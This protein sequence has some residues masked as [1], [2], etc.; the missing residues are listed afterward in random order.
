MKVVYISRRYLSVPIK[1]KILLMGIFFLLGGLI[2]CGQT[3][4]YVNSNATG[5]NN[6]SSWAD[7]FTDLQPALNAAGASFDFDKRIWVAAGTYRPTQKAGNGIEERDQSFT[8]V[9]NAKVYGGFT[10][11]EPA[12]FN[13][14]LRNIRANETILSGDIG[15]TGDVADNSYH[16]IISAGPLGTARLDGFTIK[17]GNANGTTSSIQYLGQNFERS[18]CG[19]IYSRQ[20]GDNYFIANCIVEANSGINYGG[21]YNFSSGPRMQNCI[22]RNNIATGRGTLTGGAGG[23]SN[24]SGSSPVVVNCLITGNKGDD[25]G[26]VTNTEFCS[27]TY[28]NCTISGNT[29]L[30][31]PGENNDNGTGGGM[32]NFGYSTATLYNC[33]VWGN[34][35]REFDNLSNLDNMSPFIIDNTIIEGGYPGTPVLDINPQFLNP[36]SAIN[37]PTAAGDYHVTCNSVAI[38]AGGSSLYTSNL[39]NLDLDFNARIIGTKIDIGAYEF[40]TS[41]LQTIVVQSLAPGFPFRYCPGAAINV[42]FIN[43]NCPGN[44]APGNIFTLQL[45]DANGNFITPINLGNLASANGGNISGVI[46][47]NATA[48]NGYRIRII[49]SSQPFISQPLNIDLS[50]LSIQTAS[51]TISADAAQICAG[52]NVV[53][54]SIINNVGAN[55]SW[56]WKKNGINVGTNSSGYSDNSLVSSDVITCELTNTGAC[57]GPA[58]VISNSISVAVNSV[59]PTILINTPRL[60]ICSGETANFSAVISGGGNNPS[61]Q[62]KKNGQ[63]VGTNTTTYNAAG[64]SSADLIT[65]ELTSSAICARPASVLSNALQINVAPVLVPAIRI[66]ANKN[67]IC[68]GDPVNFLATTTNGGS[69]PVFQ[70]KKNMV[71]VG[72]NTISYMDASLQSTDVITC[73][74]QSNATC[75]SPS[76]T[77]SNQLRVTVGL[78]TPAINIIAQRQEICVG[79]MADFRAVI[80]NGGNAPFFQWKKNGISVGTNSSLFS[81]NGLMSSDIISCT[82]TSSSGCVTQA[83]VQSN[84]LQIPVNPLP[85][86][87]LTKSNDINCLTGQAKLLAT[88]GIKYAWQPA[89]GLQNIDI[90]DP[91]VRPSQP[92]TYTVKISTAKNCSATKSINV[93][94]SKEG[95]YDLYNS[96]TP[97]NDGINDC[98]GVRHLL[99]ISNLDF[100]IYNRWGD[101]VFYTKNA[102]QCWDGTFK[103]LKQETGNYI[104]I[105]KGSGACGLLDK[106]GTVLLIR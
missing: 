66:A 5:L 84:S 24:K 25:G 74:L 23:L 53:F 89:E 98:F 43:N 7:A 8:L 67:E 38:N 46:P 63:N 102:S 12:N 27:S 17:D 78:V 37:A 59:V 86:I 3:V 36:V 9:R 72:T 56:Q 29:A 45:S 11:V 103:G 16:V 50:I 44:F 90:P 40:Q 20:G 91:V 69:N 10:G 41:P 75:V 15:I 83:N 14:S 49:S 58:S 6:G 92:T 104:Y 18:Y 99:N 65:C 96:F 32:Q 64:L 62:W 101:R 70:W 100:S 22:I 1:G 85:V 68:P 35:A 61:F 60:S 13:L 47:A 42:G 93:N 26:G 55:P 33:I 77:V 88:G 71:N 52:D 39:P 51:I 76:I 82:L 80:S 31:A 57:G 95:K 87:S 21:I 4:W 105:L 30:G 19:G 81:D 48:G 79:E 28:I 73:E 2:A 34:T 97:N 106:K 94:V 54:T